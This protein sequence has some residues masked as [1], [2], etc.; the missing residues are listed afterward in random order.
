MWSTTPAATALRGMDSNFAE[1]SWAKVIPPSALMA[2]SP[3]V[4]SL[5]VPDN[6]MPM[7][8]SCWSCASDSKKKSIER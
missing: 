3:N 5:A 7:A 1:P 2:S 8:R 6:T 4:P